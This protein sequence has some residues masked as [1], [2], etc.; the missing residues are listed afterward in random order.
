MNISES[1]EKEE[2][3]RET[4]EERGKREQNVKAALCNNTHINPYTNHTHTRLWVLQ[5]QSAP[6]E[7]WVW[8]PSLS[9]FPLHSTHINVKPLNFK[10]VHP[11][12]CIKFQ[13]S[14][15]LGVITNSNL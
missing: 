9:P 2:R 15:I 1:K 10:K 6:I 12:H 13:K 8:E 5:A 11:I 3:E 7:T 14:H 4:K